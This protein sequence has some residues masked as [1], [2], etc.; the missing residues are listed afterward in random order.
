MRVVGNNILGIGGNGAV[1][2]LIVV[3]IL[4]NQTKMNIGLLK[5]RGMQ[6]GDGFHYI[7]CYF[8]SSLFR[9]YFFVLNQYLSVDT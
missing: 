3:N 6:P 1:D 8:F 5:Q 2:K 9:K 7:V 4:L